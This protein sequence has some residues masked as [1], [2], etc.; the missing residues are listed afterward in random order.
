[1]SVKAKQQKTILSKKKVFPSKYSCRYV[2]YSFVNPAERVLPKD[3]KIVVQKLERKERLHFFKKIVFPK[4]PL[5]T[6]E[7]FLSI[8]PIEFRHKAEIFSLKVR[9]NFENYTFFQF[10]I[11]SKIFYGH[12]TAVA[13]VS[14]KSFCQKANFFSSM[15]S[16]FSKLV[17]F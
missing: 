11:F 13:S 4:G 15:S 5:D 7:A 1:M 16:I 2:K 14:T 8:L 3:R 6:W 10:H 9:K 12:V 17:L